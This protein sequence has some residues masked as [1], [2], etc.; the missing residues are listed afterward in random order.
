VT[1]GS[2]RAAFER[3]AQLAR[4]AHVDREALQALHRLADVLAADR[5]GDDRPARRR[6]SAR[7]A[8]RVAVDVTST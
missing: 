7:S 1:I 8:P 2:G 6:C 3:V 4:I 5:A